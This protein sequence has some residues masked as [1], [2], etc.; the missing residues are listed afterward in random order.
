MRLVRTAQP[1]PDRT[2]AED[3]RERRAQSTQQTARRVTRNV[4]QPARAV[5]Q[6]PPVTVRGTTGSIPLHQKTRG[7]VRRQF[8]YSLGTTGAEIRLPAVPMLRPGWRLL[9]GFL[10]FLLGAALYLAYNAPAL[11]VGLIE[12]SGLK[13][14]KPADIE[15]IINL[16]NLPIFMVDT[17]KV[18]TDIQ[19]FFPDLKDIRVQATLP[20]SVKITAVERKPVLGWTNGD[21]TVWVD[22]EGYIF[23]PRGKVKNLLIIEA[24]TQPPVVKSEEALLA[25]PEEPG[26]LKDAKEAAAVANSTVYAQIMDPGIIFAAQGLKKHVPDG[27]IIIHTAKDGL[28]WSDPAGW[29]VYIGQ[30]LDNIEMKMIVYEAIVAK[31][32]DE[33]ITPAVISVENVHAPYYRLE[34]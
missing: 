8:Y 23:P 12:Y 2:R 28:G 17:Q 29:S 33:G 9:S 27:T 26:S 34:Q 14:V 25:T 13:R 10:V 19:N 11:R 32:S 24:D 30:N 1:K 21:Q 22:A 16:Q 15:E 31:L 6:K 4:I 5:P 3:V 7:K 18:T 20:A